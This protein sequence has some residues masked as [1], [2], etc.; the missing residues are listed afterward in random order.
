MIYKI[1]SSAANGPVRSGPVLFFFFKTGTE[2]YRSG[3]NLIGSV[4][5]LKKTGP[6]WDRTGTGLGPKD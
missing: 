1:I 5:L 6:D 3:P 4:Y 2:F